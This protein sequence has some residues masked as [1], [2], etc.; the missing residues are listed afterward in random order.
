MSND[1]EELSY[2]CAFNL[3]L[4]TVFLPRLKNLEEKLR[5]TKWLKRLKEAC[6]TT[7]KEMRTRNDIVFNLVSQIK[8]GQ[9]KSP[10]DS[11]PPCK[12]LL[13]VG[14]QLEGESEQFLHGSIWTKARCPDLNEENENFLLPNPLPK[15]GAFCSIAVVNNDSDDSD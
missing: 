15:V 6:I 11:D 2:D 3:L 1:P 10:F 4:G 12:D 13:K 5:A 8:E 9:L 14:N 7:V